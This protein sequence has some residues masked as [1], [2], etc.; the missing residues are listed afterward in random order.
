M[1]GEG[2]LNLGGF[3]YSEGQRRV[4]FQYSSM[5]FMKTYEQI[6]QEEVGV[7]VQRCAAEGAVAVVVRRNADGKTWTVSVQSE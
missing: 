7:F 5:I 4:Q 1:R 6:L 2:Y 3:V